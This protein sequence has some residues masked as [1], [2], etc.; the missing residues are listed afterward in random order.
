MLCLVDDHYADWHKKGHPEG[1]KWAW[2]LRSDNC[3]ICSTLTELHD[4][5]LEEV[6]DVNIDLD[7]TL[8]EIEPW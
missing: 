5:I 3:A 8:S 4:I 2:T 6:E 1:D 7:N